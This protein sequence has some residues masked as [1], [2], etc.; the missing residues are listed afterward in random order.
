MP[1]L[2]K[3]VLTPCYYTAADQTMV[4]RSGNLDLTNGAV[5]WTV[6]GYRLPT[7]AE[8]EKAARGG[9]NGNRFPWGDTISHTN[10]NYVST[11]DDAYEGGSTRGYHPSY[12]VGSLPYTS[13]VGGFAP[14]Q[15]GLYN[16]AGNVSEWCWDMHEDLW[17]SRPEASGEDSRGP[18][19]NSVYR[20]RRGGTWREVAW[21]SRSSARGGSF[22]AGFG[23]LTV[24]FRCARGL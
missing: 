21:Y 1:V 11:V 12:N 22:G 23:G 2:K 10:A 20:V 8:W 5:K 4:Y 13:P 15:Y 24:G 6:T 9:I 7:E 18:N 16:L 19:L 17:Y 14:N 3:R